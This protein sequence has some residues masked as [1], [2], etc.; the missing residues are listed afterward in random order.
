MPHRPTLGKAGLG[1]RNSAAP[2]NKAK[3]AKGGDK[4]ATLI[5][6]IIVMYIWKLRRH[7]PRTI[8]WLTRCFPTNDEH[9]TCASGSSGL[10]FAYFFSLFFV[11]VFP[12]LL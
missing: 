3:Q 10:R 12:L 8:A 6:I 1:P 7:N 4:R 9:K 11:C 2:R 5:D